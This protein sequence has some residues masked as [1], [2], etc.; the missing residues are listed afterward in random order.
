MAFSPTKKSFIYRGLNKIN[1]DIIGNLP[2]LKEREVKSVVHRTIG[3][4]NSYERIGIGDEQTTIPIFIDRKSSF[5]ALVDFFSDKRPFIFSYQ[6]DLS[7]PLNLVGNLRE[8]L[9]TDGSGEMTLVFT[10]AQS[11]EDL[12]YGI[13]ISDLPTDP[14][15]QTWL[16]K[17]KTYGQNVFD[18]TSKKNEKIG[19]FTSTI[20]QYAS[21]LENIGNGVGGMSSI[22]TTPINSIKSSVSRVTGGIQAA[23]SGFQNAI[24]AILSVPDVI[25]GIIDQFL[26]IGDQLSS[27]FD[28]GTKDNQIKQ[29]TEF[30]GN[31]AEEFISVSG[32]QS[33]TSP[34]IYYEVTDDDTGEVSVEFRP[35]NILDQTNNVAISVLLLSSILIAMYQGAQQIGRW[36]TTDL[37]NLRDKTESIYNYIS[38]HGIPSDIQYQMDIAR[39]QFFATFKILVQKAIKTVDVYLNMPR[40]LADVVYDVNGN[41]DYYSDTKKL[42]NIVGEVAEGKITVISNA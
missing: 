26:A 22:I 17:L 3:D 16:D 19:G 20:S 4:D 18:F 2:L 5:D 11:K 40:F 30:L 36:N 33:K 1:L 10:T 35:E 34:D 42:N 37:D 15:D 24:Q 32:E 8:E 13:P 28:T 7:Q 9:F 39:S 14:P 23:I 6:G 41:F 27:L 25:D 29:S 38:S 21:A 31:V 12:P